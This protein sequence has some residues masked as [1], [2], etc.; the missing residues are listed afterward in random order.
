M[1]HLHHMVSAALLGG[2][3]L[4]SMQK[5]P[6]TTHDKDEKLGAHFSTAADDAAQKVIIDCL[7]RYS[8]GVPIIAE[9]QEFSGKMPEDCIVVDPLDGTTNYYNGAKEYGVIIT[10]LAKGQPT[11]AVIYLPAF[12]LIFS[13]KRGEE[14]DIGTSRETYQRKLDLKNERPLDKAMIGTDLG[15]WMT[16]QTDVLNKVVRP[17][18]QRFTM[19]SLM[20]GACG[21]ADFLMGR[22][23]AYFNLNIAKVWDLA[24]GALMVREAGGIALAPDGSELKFDTLN[25]EAVFAVNQQVA[26]IILEHTKAWKR[27]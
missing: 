15:P 2:E 7:S 3:H 1:N 8:F 9:E 22:T 21:T 27:S 23:V 10:Q 17:L 25:C 13:A 18:A 14:C 6:L 5:A 16:D 19:R 20:S 26:D 24:A 12:D 11:R 4:K